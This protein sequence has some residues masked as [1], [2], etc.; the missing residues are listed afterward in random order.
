MLGHIYYAIG[1]LI[2]LLSL[3]MIINF[4][5]ISSIKEW[6]SKYKKITGKKPE[7]KDF[8]NEE[9]R[10]LYSGIM[11]LSTIEFTWVVGGLLTGNWYA[12]LS[13][14]IYS[15]VINL[16]SRPIKYTIIDKIIAFHFLFLKFLLYLFFVINH[17]HLHYDILTIIKSL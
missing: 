15:L 14:L 16:I 10:K 4:K 9:E 6:F 12:F 17:F 8:R 13:L 11:V 7:T 2:V 5:K 3:S 1:L